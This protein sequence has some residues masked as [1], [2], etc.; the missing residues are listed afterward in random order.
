VS[1][2]AAPV[3]PFRGYRFPPETISHAVWLYHRF[4]LSH[5]DGEGCSPNVGSRSVM[6]PSVCAAASS[7]HCLQ[8]S[9]VGAIRNVATSGTWTKW[10]SRSISIG[11]GYGV[12]STRMEPCWTSWCRV[13]ATSTPQNA[14]CIVF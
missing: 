2:S 8:A 14:S 7:A 5:R 12:P 9:F 6:K 4:S 3:S 10:R 13:A 1:A 11:T